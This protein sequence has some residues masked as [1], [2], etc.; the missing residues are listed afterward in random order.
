MQR[1]QFCKISKPCR[2]KFVR[3]GCACGKLA[4][5]RRDS[6]LAVTTVRS[7]RLKSVADAVGKVRR[8]RF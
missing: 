5:A 3:R 1:G 2:N 7:R 4:Q 6:E 8:G